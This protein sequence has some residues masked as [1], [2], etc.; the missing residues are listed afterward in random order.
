ML[1]SFYRNLLELD[2]IYLRLEKNQIWRTGD[3]RDA[4][5]F[6]RGETASSNTLLSYYRSAVRRT[7]YDD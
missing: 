4:M 5:I 2:D 3:I 7:W 6:W 1:Y